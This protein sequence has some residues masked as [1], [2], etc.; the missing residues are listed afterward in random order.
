MWAGPDKE[1]NQRWK[2]FSQPGYRTEHQLNVNVPM[3]NRIFYFQ[4]LSKDEQG[5]RVDTRTRSCTA[6]D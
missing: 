2:T 4:F 3:V 6:R 1:P 5:R